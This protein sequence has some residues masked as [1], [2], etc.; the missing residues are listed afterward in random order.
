MIQ[1]VVYRIGL[2]S[3]RELR[4]SLK[5]LNVRILIFWRNKCVD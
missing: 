3:L 4:L 5:E 2:G 1:S